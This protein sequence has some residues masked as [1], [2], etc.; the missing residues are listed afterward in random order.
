MSNRVGLKPCPSFDIFG[1]KHDV[2]AV[3][4]AH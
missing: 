1:F 4:V 3:D 2:V